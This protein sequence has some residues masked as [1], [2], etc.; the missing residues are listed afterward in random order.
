M[1]PPLI[2]SIPKGARSVGVEVSE[3]EAEEMIQQ[4]P[5]E[6]MGEEDEECRDGD[7]DL[8][9]KTGAAED[10]PCVQRASAGRGEEEP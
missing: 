9:A 7:F 10:D 8:G 2:V 6:V 5:G 1:E 3:E 4:H